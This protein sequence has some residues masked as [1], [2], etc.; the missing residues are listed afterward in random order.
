[1]SNLERKEPGERDENSEPGQENLPESMRPNKQRLIQTLEIEQVHL[2][3]AI[4][5]GRKEVAE[6]LQKQVERLEGQINKMIYEESEQERKSFI[7]E[8]F[9]QETLDRAENFAKNF[10]AVVEDHLSNAKDKK[11]AERILSLWED[12]KSGVRN[13]VIIGGQGISS[14]KQVEKILQD[15]IESLGRKVR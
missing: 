6:A 5:N 13:S 11:D 2:N 4:K 10:G 3:D 8:N 12:F 9:E 15:A 1:M 14:V 7:V